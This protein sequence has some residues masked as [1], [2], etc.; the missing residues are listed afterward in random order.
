MLVLASRYLDA[1]PPKLSGNRRALLVAD[2]MRVVVH[3]EQGIVVD[4]AESGRAFIHVSFR[5][6]LGGVDQQP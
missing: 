5:A 3:I 4:L 6:D 1:A 2:L